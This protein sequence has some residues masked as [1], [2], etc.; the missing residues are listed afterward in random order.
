MSNH[1]AA[2]ALEYKI[3]IQYQRW[4]RFERDT[5]LELGCVEIQH[6]HDCTIRLLLKLQR[7][8]YHNKAKLRGQAYT[9]I[10]CLVVEKLAEAYGYSITA[11]ELAS[12]ASKLGMRCYPLENLREQLKEIGY[13]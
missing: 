11:L 5:I 2:F 13:E 1:K 9:G 10:F 3:E 6:F 7:V 12:A 4:Q 8:G